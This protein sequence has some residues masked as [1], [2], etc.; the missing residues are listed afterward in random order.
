MIG[1]VLAD[2]LEKWI[3]KAKEIGEF[4]GTFSVGGLKA[5][6]LM[7]VLKSKA[8]AVAKAFRGAAKALTEGD[9]AREDTKKVNRDDKFESLE[10]NKD[11]SDF[12]LK[13]QVQLY[14]KQAEIDKER[15]PLEQKLQSL[16][17][18]GRH[19]EA[20]DLKKLQELRAKSAQSDLDIAKKQ[21]EIDRVNREEKKKIA[22]EAAARAKQAAEE[23]KRQAKAA[24][25]A[26]RDFASAGKSLTDARAKS[27][28]EGTHVSLQDLAN[29][30]FRQ[31]RKGSDARE[32]ILDSQE[33][34]NLQG[35]AKDISYSPEERADFYNRAE[36]IKKGIVN[37]RDS[38]KNPFKQLEDH[39]KRSADALD[40]FAKDGIPIKDE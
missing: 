30:D 35:M 6:D 11:K 17:A 24:F 22:E 37:L 18:S 2:D 23:S 7:E 5:V 29:M 39:A 8:V 19:L 26:Y 1:M 20:E 21:A 10:T 40:G 33:V 3:D 25:D 13:E 16:K 38:D 27:L 9:K 31:F 15:I 14:E 36:Q 4:W 12:L 28:E 32:D 34:V